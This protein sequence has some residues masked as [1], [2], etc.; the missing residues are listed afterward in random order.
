MNI[1]S[2]TELLINM[3]LWLLIMN[4]DYESYGAGWRRPMGCLKLQVIFRKR[5]ANYRALLRK[6]TCKDKASDGSSPLCICIVC[7]SDWLWIRIIRWLLIRIIEFVD[8][9]IWLIIAKCQFVTNQCGLWFVYSSFIIAKCSCSFEVF[10]YASFV[11]LIVRRL[12]KC[13]FEAFVY[14]SFVIAKCIR[15][16]IHVDSLRIVWCTNQR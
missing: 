16:A 9:S 5:A 8:E 10:V 7:E 12:I 1:D 4:F 11:L 15:I 6:M 13:S 2:Y 14:A 3:D